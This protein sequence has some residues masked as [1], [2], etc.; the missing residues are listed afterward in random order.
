VADKPKIR[1][2]HLKI[3][4]HLALG[5]TADKLA[6][7]EESFNYMDLEVQAYR[8]WN[9]L[10]SDFKDGKIE[11]AC[12]LAPIAMELFS[13]RM[14]I[15]LILQMHKAGST[16]VTNKSAHI[17][18]IEDFKGKS[19]LIPH[20]LSVH[21]MLFDKLLR[22]SG[23]KIGVGK[24]VVFDVVAP[25]DI[26]EI[27]EWDEK[28]TVGGFIVAEPFGAQVVKAGDGEE[29]RISQ[30]IWKNHP[31]CVLAIREDVIGSNPDGVQELVSSLVKSGQM[32]TKDPKG[33]AK[34]GAQFLSQ[35]GDIIESV[36]SDPRKKVTY[37][38]LFPVID[39]YETIQVYLTQTISAMSKK[40]DLEKFVDTQ[41]AREAGA[42]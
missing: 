2:G 7:G 11:A 42:K 19:V 35:E 36:L 12:M 31:C 32:I 30:D 27:I 5:V 22:D 28:G 34:I 13:S 15:R 3:T 24:D 41:F 20:Y 37:D 9:P 16:V 33:A 39:D 6:K 29:F 10:A 26:P 1:V 17:K 4:D 23:L 38:E 14:P 18:N 25:S 40:I 21:H 8:G